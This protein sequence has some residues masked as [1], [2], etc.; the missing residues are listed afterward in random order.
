MTE[1]RKKMED[2]MRLHGYAE[3]TR[4][5]YV[6]AVKVLAKHYGRSPDKLTQEEIR[7]FFLYL[8]KEKHSSQST[9]TIYLSAIKFFYE[10]TLNRDWPTLNLIRSRK[11]RK[12]SVV[13]TFEEVNELISDVNTRKIRTCLTVIY[14]CGLRLSEGTHLRVCDID[15]KRMQIGIRNAKGGHDRNVPMPKKTLKIL[16]S[17]WSKEKPQTW[18]FPSKVKAGP[19]CD[20]TVQIA[21]KKVLR[22]SDINKDASVHSLRHSFATLLLENGVSLRVIQLI[23]GHK[24]A[25]TTAIYTHLT[26]KISDALNSTL[27]NIMD[28]L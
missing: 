22:E 10:K 19:I 25:R 6:N 3:R 12:L 27:N 5:S 9:V 15:G 28:D 13:L 1:L 20:T 24:S 2:D 18:L 26:K 11:K 21:F 7:G 8:I 23:L 17:Y 4:K 16:R 14:S